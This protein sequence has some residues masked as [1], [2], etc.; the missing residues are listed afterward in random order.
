MATVDP[1]REKGLQDYRKKLLEHKE[2]ESRLKE[3]K[4][5]LDIQKWWLLFWVNQPSIELNQVFLVRLKIL[6]S[7][8]FVFYNLRVK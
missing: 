1:I 8:W 4:L 2:V 7:F 3:R 5:N 6:I